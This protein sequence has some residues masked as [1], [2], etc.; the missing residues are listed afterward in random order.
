MELVLH[1]Q[2]HV[3]LQLWPLDMN[4]PSL[5]LWREELPMAAAELC[6]AGKP[7]VEWKTLDL[8]NFLLETGYEMIHRARPLL[9]SG[10]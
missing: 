7:L 3:L 5:L 6:L 4:L 8:P 10:C 1:P 2:V 9:G